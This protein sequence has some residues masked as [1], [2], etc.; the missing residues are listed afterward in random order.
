VQAQVLRLKQVREALQR[1]PRLPQLAHIGPGKAAGSR[2]IADFR[3]IVGKPHDTQRFSNPSDVQT[4]RREAVLRVL[5]KQG[6][7]NTHLHDDY[8]AYRGFWLSN[9]KVKHLVSPIFL[10]CQQV[11]Q[12]GEYHFGLKLLLGIRVAGESK[13]VMAGYVLGASEVGAKVVDSTG[14]DALDRADQLTF[15]PF[16]WGNQAILGISDVHGPLCGV[17]LLNNRYI[18]KE[19]R[20][21]DA[22]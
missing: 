8:T 4:K 1:V 21:R 10:R 19:L 3:P 13:L 11:G 6:V 5:R 16:A 7:E 9:H 15:L 2:D 20:A 14:L 18:R 22:H 12:D 17:F